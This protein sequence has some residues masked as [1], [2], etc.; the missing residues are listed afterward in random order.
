MKRWLMNAKKIAEEKKICDKKHFKF[1]NIHI[2][3]Y[4]AIPL[5]LWASIMLVQNHIKSKGENYS[6][7]SISY[8]GKA[9]DGGDANFTI[10]YPAKNLGDFF[11]SKPGLAYQSFYKKIGKKFNIESIQED[12]SFGYIICADD[13]G[14]CNVF[15]RSN[16][17][18]MDILLDKDKI[19]T[20][21]DSV[22]LENSSINDYPDKIFTLEEI[23]RLNKFLTSIG[24]IK[25]EDTDVNKRAFYVED[26]NYK[27]SAIIVFPDKIQDI[28]TLEDVINIH[29]KGSYKLTVN[30]SIAKL[31]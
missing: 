8:K 11:D 18:H 30:I 16:Y 4:I 5:L 17:S 28:K 19:I 14:V 9:S 29:S 20:K 1:I 22:Y 27:Y 21:I 12:F 31:K 25:Y 7:P 2:F 23:V 24:E 15:D 10:H 3:L 26:K 13:L 6:V